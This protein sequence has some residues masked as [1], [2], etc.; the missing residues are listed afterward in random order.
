MPTLSNSQLKA[1][2]DAIDTR[3]PEGFRHYAIILTP[4][5]TGV[6]V[7]ELTGLRLRDVR[8]DEGTLRVLGKGNKERL[9]PVGKGLKRLL[10]H[11]VSC[12]RPEPTL[13][14]FDFV[15]L[16][17]DG[18]P[19]TKNRVEAPMKKYSATAGLEGLRCSP[20]T[21]RHTAAVSFLRN[22]GTHSASSGC[23]DTLPSK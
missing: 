17:A 5:D 18:R 2:V 4:L 12:L 1:L 8:L 11:Y 20:H 23:W 19:L 6:M 15:F 14:G 7:G 16:T 9:V 13:L 10:W 3:T 21:L 22:G